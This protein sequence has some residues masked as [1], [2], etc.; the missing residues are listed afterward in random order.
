MYYISC[1]VKMDNYF[2]IQFFHDDTVN[3]VFVDGGV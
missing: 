1:C 3:A 2:E